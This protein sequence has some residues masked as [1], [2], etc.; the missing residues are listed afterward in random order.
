VNYKDG[1]YHLQGITGPDEYT[2]LVDDNYYT[3]RLLKYHF[4]FTYNFYLSNSDKLANIIS[5]LNVSEDELNK[6]LDISNNIHLPF[7]KTLNIYAQDSSFLNK[8][9]LNLSMIPKE[10]FPLLLNYHP[11]YLYKHQVLKQ[12]DTL[13]AM[14]LMDIEDISILEDSFNYYEPITTHDSSL[15]KCIYS[16]AAFKLNKL[17]LGCKYFEEVLG[18][19]YYNT[20]EN[21]DH[22]LHVANL[23]GSYLGFIYGVLGLRIHD[24]YISISPITTQRISSYELNILYRGKNIMFKVGKTLEITTENE[25]LIKVFDNKILVNG[26]YEKDL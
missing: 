5:H 1:V 24:D 17:D 7:S 8:P 26:F 3:N 18:T 15:S 9:K 2:T 21:T 6:I 16:I 22:G 19:D 14:V 25:V 10:K 12:A 13:L 20:N 11:L 23:G 4:E